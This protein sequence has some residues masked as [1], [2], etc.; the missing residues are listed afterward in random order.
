MKSTVIFTIVVLSAMSLKGQVSYSGSMSQMG[1]NGFQP[2]VNIDSLLDEPGLIGLGPYFYM[3]GELTVLEGKPFVGMAGYQGSLRVIQDAK[4]GA[5]F[6]VYSHV[7]KWKTVKVK[8]G[9]TSSGDIQTLIENT[10]KENN[11]SLEEP[12]PFRI[13]TQIDNLT[14]H[15]VT[16]RSPEVD[17]YLEGKKSLI[18]SYQDIEGE[19]IGFYSHQGQGIYTHKDSYIHVHFISGDEEIVGHIDQLKILP[20]SIQILLPA[21]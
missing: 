12:F 13:K 17:G 14:V 5:P 10:A 8:A 20:K 21:D 16:P 9:A 15:V 6:F 4:A 2:T 19:I 18:F 7:S 1:K 11:L 3:Q